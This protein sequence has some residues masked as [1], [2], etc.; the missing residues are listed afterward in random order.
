MKIQNVTDAAFKAYGRVL[1]ED[2]EVAE[3][4]KEMQ[5]DR[6]STRLNSSH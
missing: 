2:Y 3:L 4:I 5:K 6:K 1:T